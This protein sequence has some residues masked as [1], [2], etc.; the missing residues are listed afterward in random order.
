MARCWVCGKPSV[1]FVQVFL[2]R[3]KVKSYPICIEDSAKFLL[4][5]ELGQDWLRTALTSVIPIRKGTIPR[6]KVS[7]RP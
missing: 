2:R 6:F 7:L 3:K 1:A 5:Q 4:Y